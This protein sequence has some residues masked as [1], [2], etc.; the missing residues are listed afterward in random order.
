MDPMIST[1]SDSAKTDNYL[2][3]HSKADIFVEKQI[4]TQFKTSNGKTLAQLSQHHNCLLIFRRF[5]RFGGCAFC[6]RRLYQIAKIY[7]SLLQLNIIPVVI[8]VE[9]DEEVKEILEEHH[10]S[11]PILKEMIRLCDKEHLLAKHFGVEFK[12]PDVPQVLPKLAVIEKDEGFGQVLGLPLEQFE[13]ESFLVVPKMFL[14]RDSTVIQSFNHGLFGD[15]PDVISSMIFDFSDLLTVESD[16][17]NSGSSSNLLDDLGNAGKSPQMCKLTKKKKKASFEMLSNEMYKRLE[18]QN[19]R[20]AKKQVEK[21]MKPKTTLTFICFIQKTTTDSERNSKLDFS[22]SV[23]DVLQDETKRKYFKVYAFKELNA[24]NITFYETVHQFK[25]SKDSL[26][27]KFQF[28]KKVFADYLSNIDSPNFINTS[29]AKRV[30]IKKALESN[31]NSENISS[32]F[33]EVLNE[34]MST[35]IPDIY[36]RFKVSKEFEQMFV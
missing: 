9:S 26:D 4:F 10:N 5:L 17:S 29:D 32:I 8:H 6:N 33:D 15:A 11:N 18:A 1:H 2:N 25:Q 7:K 13:G 28:A 24:E 23:H 14:I 34:V 35:V 31:P 36:M 22:L 27:V 12:H 19:T 16:S 3:S 21:M 30:E 20:K